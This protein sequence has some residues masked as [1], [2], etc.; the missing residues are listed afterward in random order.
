VFASAET[1][2]LNKAWVRFGSKDCEKYR[3][4]VYCGNVIEALRNKPQ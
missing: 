1:F 4:D 3:D 2:F